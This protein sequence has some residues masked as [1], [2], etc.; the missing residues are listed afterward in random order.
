MVLF[1]GAGVSVAPPSSYPQLREL[2]T[3]IG[4]EASAKPREGE[5]L[6]RFLGRLSDEGVAVHEKIRDLLT[7]PRSR[8]SPLHYDLLRLFGSA[9]DVRLV[10]TNFDTHF[11]TAAAELFD[12]PMT[13][14]RAPALPLGYRVDGLV[15]LHGTVVPDPSQVV[16]TDG[17]FGR[18]YLTEGWAR[19]FLQDLFLTYTVV[20][21]GYSHNDPVMNYLARGLPPQGGGKTAPVRRYAL[22]PAKSH[23]HWRFLG[24]EP[25]TYSLVDGENPH[26]ALAD[27]VAQW[28]TISSM[29]HGEHERR[30]REIVKKG[31][32][33]PRAVIPA[34][35]GVERG[36]GCP[37]SYDQSGRAQRG[38][39]GPSLSGFGVSPKNF[40]VCLDAG[41]L[42]ALQHQYPLCQQQRP[43]GNQHRGNHG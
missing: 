13:V 7:D 12:E 16:L 42:P 18:A 17:D 1:A 9:R 5:P 38:P 43:G 31:P 25:V 23:G 27:S 33:G 11:E 40:F 10:T 8:P 2:A 20:F 3:Q 26:Q 41:A 39:C 22:T 19:R 6:D 14:Y 35:S 34:R 24:I 36:L 28:A 32:P 29:E 21:A 30:I 15:Y 4:E 37:R